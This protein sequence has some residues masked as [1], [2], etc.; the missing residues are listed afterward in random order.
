MTRSAQHDVVLATGN[1]GKLQEFRQLLEGLPLRLRSSAELGLSDPEESASTFVEN[2]LLKARA[3]SQATG[4]AAIA[5]DSGLVV[6]A[7]DGAPGL[8]SARYAGLPQNATRN[9]EKLLQDL[10]HVP[11]QQRQARFVSVVVYLRHPLDPSPLLAE[12]YWSGSIL[13]APRGSYGFGYDP[14][15]FDATVGQAAAEMRPEI[16]HRLS[17]RGRAF[18]QLRQLLRQQIVGDLGSDSGGDLGSA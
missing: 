1:A 9:L 7:L 14:V 2:A 11:E 15:F 4:Y 8:Y 5:D 18:Q 16:K 10:A 13:F 6:D 3:A 12:G 17:H